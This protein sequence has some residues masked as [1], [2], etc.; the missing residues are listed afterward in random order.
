MK[1]E[2]IRKHYPD[3]WLLVEALQAHSAEGRRIL[4]DLAV[5]DVFDDSAQAMKSYAQLHRE[6]PQRELYVFDSERES[7]E[8][9]ERSW[10]GIRVA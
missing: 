1:W 8:V 9:K 10:L 4:E 6:S 5:V 7:L 3:Q 2:E